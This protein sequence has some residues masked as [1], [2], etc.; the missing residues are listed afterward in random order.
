[1]NGNR[2]ADEIPE[3]V[4]RPVPI[5]LSMAVDVMGHSS[6]PTTRCRPDGARYSRYLFASPTTLRT[7]QIGAYRRWPSARF[8]ET[9]ATGRPSRSRRFGD[10]L[11]PIR[12][13]ALGGA[14]PAAR[15]PNPLRSGERLDLVEG[16]AEAVSLD[17]ELVAALQ[18]EPEPLARAEVAA[19]RRA[20]SAVMPRL[21][22]TISLIRRGGTP[23]AT[24]TRCWVIPSGSMYSSRRISPGWIGSIVGAVISSPLLS[25]VVHDLDIFWARCRP[26]EADSPLVVDADAVGVRSVALSFSSRLPGGTRRSPICSAASRMSSLRRAARWVG[27]SRR[28]DRWRCHTRS[29]SVA[30]RLQHTAED[31]VTRYERQSL[32][33]RD[34]GGRCDVHGRRCHG[35]LVH[36]D[37]KVPARQH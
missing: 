19:G 36:T 7:P 21:P 4:A 29:V 26:A 23:I 24:A 14:R 33:R 3:V 20:V 34:P 31:N 32:C 30:E 11:G 9:S 12:R 22:C 37:H 5:G 1:M 8:R 6:T 35:A 15:G 17:L 18:V 27:W 16:A 2:Y 10:G 28:F 25:V 13:H